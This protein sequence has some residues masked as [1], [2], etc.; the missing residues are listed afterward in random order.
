MTRKR[1]SIV[2]AFTAQTLG[3]VE[4]LSAALALTAGLWIYILAAKAKLTAQAL[5]FSGVLY[6]L[7][8]SIVLRG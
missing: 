4:L 1:K 5:I 3:P 7:F 8:L 6:L 2:D